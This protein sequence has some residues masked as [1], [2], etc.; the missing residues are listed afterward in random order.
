MKESE[1]TM[2]KIYPW[3]VHDFLDNEEKDVH[4]KTW[5]EITDF[6]EE[7]YG[8]VNT[9]NGWGFINLEGYLMIPD[10][11]ERFLYPYF[12]NGYCVAKKNGKY[13][14]IDRKNHIIFPFIYDKLIVNLFSKSLKIA[15]LLDGVW[16]IM[17]INRKTMVTL[18]YD[19]VFS[20]NNQYIIVSK[21]DK[22]GAVD[23]YQNVVLDFEWHHLEFVEDNFCA[24]KTVDVFFDKKKLESAGIY[25]SEYYKHCT[26]DYQK[27]VFGVI[28]IH[29]NILFPFISDSPV[30]EFNPENGRA[31]IS[32]NFWEHPELSDDD[33]CYIADSE[34][35][36]ISFSPPLSE[37]ERYSANF[38]KRCHELLFGEGT[39]PY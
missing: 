23:F 37:E 39:F 33:Y 22:Y 21:G 34:G 18:N 12:E 29:K 11:Y 26:K 24:G 38:H 1:T 7:N 2:R 32:K 17:D 36:K 25:F 10:D 3:Q 16:Q 30:R 35:N 9:D 8:C 19:E 20:V 6:D 27:I 31:K 28:D 13:G 4:Q 5:E 14:M 15:A